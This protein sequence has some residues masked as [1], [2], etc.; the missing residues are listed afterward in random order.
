MREKKGGE[1]RG[2]VRNSVWQ[3][4]REIRKC[5]WRAHENPEREN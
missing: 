3:F 5:R 2:N 1:E 4:A